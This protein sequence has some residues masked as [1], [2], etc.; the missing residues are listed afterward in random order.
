MP[1]SIFVPSSL[2][3]A[4]TDMPS[5]PSFEDIAA[6]V[7]ALA[8]RIVET[9]CLESRTLSDLLGPNI[10]LKFENLQFTGSFKDR[11]ALTKLLSLSAAQRNAGVVAVSAGNHA[12]GLAYH[13]HRLGVA[14]TIIM[15]VTA[16]ATKI[17]R[18]RHFGAKVILHGESFA[19][20]AELIPDLVE[21]SGLG[22][23]HPFD[24]PAII[25]GQGTVGLEM[26]KAVPDLDVLVVP[27]GG[28][29]LIS[30]IAIAAK[31]IK[32]G[33][34]I[35]GVQ[36]D[37]Y[38]GMAEATGLAGR[39]IGGQSIADG[40]AVKTPGLITRGV[41]ADLV[42]QVVTVSETAIEDA[43]AVLLEIE[44]TVCEGAGAAGIAAVTEHPALFREQRVGIVLSGGNIDITVL[45]SVLQR[46]LVR[47]GRVVQLSVTTMDLPGSLARITSVIA[48]AGGNIRHVAHERVFS[49]GGAKNAEIIFE[50]ELNETDARDRIERQIEA[51]GMIARISP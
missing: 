46:A 23:I 38:P 26:L 27:V 18:V 28:G 31:T 36:T 8:G 30:G 11:G 5:R 3:K 13:A 32:P 24:D 37:L 14:A 44:K 4:M 48:A 6:A 49:K 1:P 34:R 29:G 20:A 45:S 2:H 22:L 17:A 19:E 47:R 50:I 9:P 40:I 51:L 42:E 25:A 39:G 33:I 41:V 15:P 35:V 43:V 12:Q 16:A 7:S 10:F 21:R